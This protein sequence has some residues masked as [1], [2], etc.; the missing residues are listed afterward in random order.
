MHRLHP[1]GTPPQ[2][3]G[4]RAACGVTQLLPP[5]PAPRDNLT[6]Q[7][8]ISCLTT[9]TQG[10]ATGRGVPVTLQGVYAGSW[11]SYSLGSLEAGPE[12]V[13]KKYIAKTNFYRDQ[14]EE[15]CS[16]DY[17]GVPGRTPG[18][19]HWSEECTSIH[20]GMKQLWSHLLFYQKSTQRTQWAHVHVPN[21]RKVEVGTEHGK[22]GET[23][24]T[25]DIT[26]CC[27]W[28]C[29]NSTYVCSLYIRLFFF[30]CGP[31]MNR[32]LVEGVALPSPMSAVNRLQQAPAILSAEVTGYRRWMDVTHKKCVNESN[33]LGIYCKVPEEPQR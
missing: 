12:E 23:S 17:Q 33:V 1:S 6:S 16:E 30:L 24:A 10:L 11:Y 31:A 14:E 8:P 20:L 13:I 7:Q 5:A 32:Q 25:P 27:L 9:T 3:M 18:K 19:M 28:R 22:T 29:K 2:T 26:V 4:D 15:R 21:G